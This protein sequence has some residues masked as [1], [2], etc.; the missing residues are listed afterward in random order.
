MSAQASANRNNNNSG[1]KDYNGDAAMHLTVSEAM[2][3]FCRSVEL[4][5]NY[6]RG[7]YGLKIVSR[8]IL[9]LNMK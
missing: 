1:G 6:L 8:T 7:F 4:C 2:R 5:D 3:R 9:Q